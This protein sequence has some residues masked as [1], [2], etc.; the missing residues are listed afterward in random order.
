MIFCLLASPRSHLCGLKNKRKSFSTYSRAARIP[1]DPIVGAAA[2]AGGLLI[3]PL[4]QIS[5]RP[6][7]GS[8]GLSCLI[9]VRQRGRGRRGEK[10]RE[11][12]NAC[13]IHHSTTSTCR[14]MMVIRLPRS[15]HNETTLA[16]PS[17]TGVEPWAERH[18]HGLEVAIRFIT[19]SERDNW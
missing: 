12:A 10:P 5:D 13:A 9:R 4:V 2:S 1:H 7:V 15:E 6:S 11:M 19:R 18:V 3:P 16:S 8:S 17:F 14:A